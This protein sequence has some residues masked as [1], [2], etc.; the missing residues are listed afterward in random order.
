MT[1]PSVRRNEFPMP[2]QSVTQPPAPAADRSSAADRPASAVPA[3]GAAPVSTL[4]QSLRAALPI[5]LG[6]V[7]L[8]LPCGILESAAGLTWWMVAVMSVVFYSG[9]GQFMIPNMAL[10]G[11]PL[12]AIVL[13]VSLVNS[14]QMLYGASLSQF[15]GAEG[16]LLTV[17]FG[18]TV[19]DE[20]F[21]VN[22]ARFYNGDWDVP[23]ALGVN[24][25]SL[26]S[27]T[28]ANVAGAVIGA[29]VSVPTALAS[30]AMTSLFICLLCMQRL[31]RENLVAAAASVAG[32]VVCKLVGLSGPAILVGALVGVGCALACRP[33]AAA[34]GVPGDEGVDEV[35]GGAPRDG[36]GEA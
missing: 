34:A 21:G 30:F 12:A 10:A 25:C 18:A 26:T 5:V 28:L 33:R 8:G 31:T 27:W 1:V 2:H 20:S 23:R 29:I 35:A 3:P 17:L 13:S 36:E 9:A 7:V 11:N 16:R 6:Y 4:R 14:R 19:T 24:L 32:V 15:C 22:Y